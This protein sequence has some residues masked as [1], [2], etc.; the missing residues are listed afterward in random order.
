MKRVVL[1]FSIISLPK[2]GSEY[3]GIPEIYSKTTNH[4]LNKVAKEQ[5]V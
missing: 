2:R 3:L 5:N 1:N 4:L